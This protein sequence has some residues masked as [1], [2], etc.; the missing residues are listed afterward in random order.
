MRKLVRFSV[1]ALLLFILLGVLLFS[2]SI[3]TFAVLTDETLIAEI[4][5]E[6]RGP[7]EYQAYVRSG[8]FCAERSFELLGDQ[9]RID[10]EFVKWRYWALLFG[11]DSQYRLD[12]FEGRYVDVAAQNT[13]RTL[14]H[15][16]TEDTAIDVVSIAESLG[17]LNFLLDA[18]Y[19]SSTYQDVDP[20]RLYLVYKSPTGI[21]TRSRELP[22]VAEVE[23]LEVEV[24]HGCGEGNGIWQRAADWTD[25]LIADVL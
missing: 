17:R 10:A 19:G 9:W 16:L 24:R 5:F 11:L 13:E 21:F 4:R 20:T 7:Q 22:V 15:P 25:S 14:A 18:T 8:D 6:Q 1:A 3:Y 23:A 2:A 12:R